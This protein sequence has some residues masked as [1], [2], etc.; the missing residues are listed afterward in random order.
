MAVR[1]RVHFECDVNRAGILGKPALQV[2]AI[3]DLRA[4]LVRVRRFGPFK[5]FAGVAVVALG[6]AITDQDVVAAAAAQG[7]VAAT[8]IDRIVAIIAQNPVGV[9]VAAQVV[10]MG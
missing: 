4:R 2:V 8:A 6:R 3:V 9:V 5:A 10:T 1:D 7:V